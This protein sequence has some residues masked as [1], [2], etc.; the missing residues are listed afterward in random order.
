MPGVQTVGNQKNPPAVS[1]N[2]RRDFSYAKTQNPEYTG[3]LLSCRISQFSFS[4]QTVDVLTRCH[5][6][7]FFENADKITGR[8]ES[9]GSGCFGSA[10]PAGKHILR[11]LHTQLRH[12]LV[13]RKAEA[14]LEIL[15]QLGFTD[16]I[17]RLF[18]M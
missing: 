9:A 3:A 10:L 18:G 14:F 2:H 5:S 1:Q 7:K 12:V 8:T 16:I 4:L 17:K 13:E 6:G 11:H 15:G